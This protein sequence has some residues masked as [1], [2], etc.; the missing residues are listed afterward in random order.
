MKTSSKLVRDKSTTK[1]NEDE[2]KSTKNA[3]RRVNDFA[4]FQINNIST[5]RFWALDSNDDQKE[6]IKRVESKTI[7][8]QQNSLKTEGSEHTEYSQPT[9]SAEQNFI[10]RNIC[11]ISK[12]NQ[13]VS[14]QKATQ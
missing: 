14:H 10:K 8:P 11:N 4:E 13:K 2:R 3:N 9:V 5:Q 12:L 6:F 7:L 1:A